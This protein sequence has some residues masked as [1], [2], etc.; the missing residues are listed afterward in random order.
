MIRTI[1]NEAKGIM[2]AGQKRG[3]LSKQ[4]ITLSAK[5]GARKQTEIRNFCN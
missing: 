5:A 1:K 4:R 3:G 2:E